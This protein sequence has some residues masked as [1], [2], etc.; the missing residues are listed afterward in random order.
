MNLI[1]RLLLLLIILIGIVLGV[2]FSADNPQAL[3]VVA[4]G[5]PLPQLP[6]GIWLLL[7]VLIGAVLGYLVSVMPALKL[8][9]ENM[10]LKRKLKRRDR[11][12]EKLRK[13]PLKPARSGGSVAKGTSLT[14][15]S[16]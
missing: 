6:A 2:W 3:T 14:S 1:K 12:L 13:L 15:V 7:M 4:L 5:F 9:N 16:E 8:K 11:E 10:S